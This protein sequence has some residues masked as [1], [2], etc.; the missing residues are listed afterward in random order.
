MM[1]F[2]VPATSQD[3][4][5]ALDYI[6]PG[7]F[8][9]GWQATG[10]ELLSYP[11]NMGYL[12]SDDLPLLYEFDCIWY[13]TET[14]ESGN[15]QMIIEIF[16]FPSASDVFGFYSLSYIEPPEPDA[17]VVMPNYQ[18]PPPPQI[19]TVR[20]VTRGGT[21]WMEGYQDR[22][23]FRIT[24]QEE[25]LNQTGLHAGIY[26][27]SNLPG[28]A[29][30]A[31]MVGILPGSDRIHGTE[32]YIRGPVG[33]D[34]LIDTGG[35]DILGFDQ[36][37]YRGVVGQ[38]RLGGGE[39]YLL[40]IAEYEDADTADAVADRLQGYFQDRDWETVMLGAMSDGTHPRGF[41]NEKHIAF[42]S[43]GDKLALLWDLSGLEELQSALGQMENQL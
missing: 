22:F 39:Y 19:D 32:R 34:L 33:L 2:T 27:L 26:M 24:V 37:D 43:V 20:H 4:L 38:Y 29:I 16:E 42:W 18:M 14:Y 8:L 10:N 12:L 28:Q 1:A 3:D 11:V 9:G 6:P 7:Y 31:N 17:I 41:S 25:F 15:D 23:Y 35:Y 36:Y 5:N 30:P 40:F 13:A 21:E